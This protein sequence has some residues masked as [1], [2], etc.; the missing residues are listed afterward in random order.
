MSL[1]ASP[2][3]LGA[4]TIERLQVLTGTAWLAG[5]M[6]L[7]GFT[8][9]HLPLWGIGVSLTTF[10]WGH[11]HSILHLAPRHI[12]PD[13]G[14]RDDRPLRPCDH[15]TPGRVRRQPHNLAVVLALNDVCANGMMP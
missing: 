14:A 11:S 1:R 10:V 13:I 5:A 2:S 12:G 7:L 8:L 15:G 6:S 4:Y 3:G 9:V